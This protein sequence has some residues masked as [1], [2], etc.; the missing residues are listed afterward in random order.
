[1]ALGGGCWK[2]MEHDISSLAMGV[3]TFV[4]VM[5]EERKVMDLGLFGEA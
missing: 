1:M 3:M 2:A 5:E 4:S